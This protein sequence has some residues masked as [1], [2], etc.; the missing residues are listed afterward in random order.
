MNKVYKTK[1]IV[2]LN[3]STC[4]FMIELYCYNTNKLMAYGISARTRYSYINGAFIRKA[5]HHNGYLPQISVR[6]IWTEIKCKMT[7]KIT[8]HQRSIKK[9]TQ[10]QFIMYFFKRDERNKGSNSFPKLL[11]QKKPCLVCL[12]NS[13]TWSSLSRRHNPLENIF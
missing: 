4:L 12:C 10:R 9:I 5:S 1:A 13:K 7:S 2:L 8:F 6:I 11:S 3:I